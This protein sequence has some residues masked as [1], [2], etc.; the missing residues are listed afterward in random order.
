MESKYCNY[1]GI[2]LDEFDLQ[3]DYSLH[4]AAGYGSAHDGNEVH[5]QLC[6]KCFDEIVNRCAVSPVK[7]PKS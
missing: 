3:G 4:S 1:C 6:S 5:L 2:T 7:V